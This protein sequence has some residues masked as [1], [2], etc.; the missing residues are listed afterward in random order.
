MTRFD[1]IMQK[2]EQRCK[3]IDKN[4]TIVRKFIEK[5]VPKSLLKKEIEAL[6]FL[7]WFAEERRE[8]YRKNGIMF[9]P[10]VPQDIGE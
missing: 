6:A 2:R 8:A 7:I 1:K 9:V 10:E 5:A 3:K 4:C